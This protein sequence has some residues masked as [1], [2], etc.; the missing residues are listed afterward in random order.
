MKKKIIPANNK[1]RAREV[2]VVTVDGENF[3]I[4]PIEKALELAKERELDLVQIT[5][6]VVP[7]VCKIIDYGKYLYK[8]NKKR[9][10]QKITT[11][12][13]VK[14]VRLGFAISDHDMEIRANSTEKFLNQGNTVRVILPLKG[15]Q[16]ALESVAREK[17]KFFI[18]MVEKKNEIK[19]EKEISKEPRGLTVVISPGA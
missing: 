11:K 9:R 4:V 17:L 5:D 18:E 14:S 8:E 13:Q 12:S 3:G 10:K 7:P 19:I 6:N 1:I 2:R 15:R 16:K